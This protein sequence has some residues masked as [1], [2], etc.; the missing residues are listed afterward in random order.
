MTCL[1]MS[2][3]TKRVRLWFKLNRVQKREKEKILARFESC[4][5]EYQKKT[6]PHL[7]HSFKSAGKVHPKCHENS[8]IGV[9][10]EAEEPGHLVYPCL[11]GLE[12]SNWSVIK[13]PSFINKMSK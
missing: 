4:E 7:Y 10:I 5:P 12:L 1:N 2:N 13:L 3:D 6:I 8:A 11:E 9:V